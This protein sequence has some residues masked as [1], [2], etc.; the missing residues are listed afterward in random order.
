MLSNLK[1]NNNNNSADE[2]LKV[3]KR[4]VRDRGYVIVEDRAKYRVPKKSEISR[5]KWIICDRYGKFILRVIFFDR[6]R[7][8]RGSVKT[9]CKMEAVVTDDGGGSRRDGGRE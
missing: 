7:S 6:K 5:K 4:W 8:D 1:N 2:V 3:V 9:D